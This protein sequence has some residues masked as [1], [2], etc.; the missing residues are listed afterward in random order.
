MKHNSVAEIRAL[1]NN[2]LVEELLFVVDELDRPLAPAPRSQVI[3]ER[4]WRRASGILIANTSLDQILCHKR[5][6][7]KDER[8]DVWVLMF[9]GKCAPGEAPSETAR[10]EVGEEA[11]IGLGENSINFFAKVKSDN[12][13]QFEYLHWAPWAGDASSLAY[14][15]AE[16]AEIKWFDTDA[17]YANLSLPAEGWYCYSPQ[18]LALIR[19]IG[20]LAS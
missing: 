10:R 12:H 2:G 15:Q 6:A 3:R 19:H 17:A 16:V 13:H 1:L 8:P 11:G 9:G 20:A 5:A 7:T 18:E 4:L 14:D